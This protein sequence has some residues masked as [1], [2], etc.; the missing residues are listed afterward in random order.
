MEVVTL[1]DCVIRA[2]AKAG[3]KFN[4]VA[5][6]TGLISSTGIPHIKHRHLDDFLEF[7]IYKAGKEATDDNLVEEYS[8]LK[9]M[10]KLH[11]EEYFQLFKD[12]N[13][14]RDKIEAMR[15]CKGKIDRFLGTFNADRRKLLLAELKKSGENLEEF[16]NHCNILN[17]IYGLMLEKERKQPNLFRVINGDVLANVREIIKNPFLVYFHRQKKDFTFCSNIYDI[18]YVL[19]LKIGESGDAYLFTG[20]KVDFNAVKRDANLKRIYEKNRPL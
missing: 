15:N 19:T 17:N 6:D 11:L 14:V 2:I 20:Y 18:C 8:K 10:D 3:A 7:S 4:A 5:V 16:E 9:G 1:E 13:E 12:L